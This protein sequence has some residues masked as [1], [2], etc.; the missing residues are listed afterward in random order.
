MTAFVLLAA[1]LAALALGFIVTPLLR[2]RAQAAENDRTDANAAIYR[3]QLAEL[4]AERT[5]GVI[6][7]ERFDE[8]RAEIERRFAEDLT[9]GDAADEASTLQWRGSRLALALGLVVPLVAGAL[10]LLVGTPGAL[11]PAARSRS[12]QQ[13]H[14]VTPEQIDAMVAQLAERLE[15]EP[16]NPEGWHM[17]ARS[18]AALERYAE[19]AKAYAKV[20]EYGGKDAGVLADY[21]DVLAMAAGRNLQGEP[22]RLIEEA[23]ALDPDHIKALALAG[24]AEF[25]RGDFAAAAATWERMLPLVRPDSEDARQ[26]RS[27]VAEARQRAGGAAPPAP[28]ASAPAAAAGSLR[29]TVRL[30]PK[31]GAQ[32]A[33]GDTLFVYARAASGPAMPLAILRRSARELPLEFALDDSM[34]MAPG[35]GLSSQP[36]VVVTARISRSGNALPQPGDLQG[37]SEPVASDAKGVDIL[38]DTVVK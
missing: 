36:R 22:M 37:A 34:A 27:N 2:R 15:R 5:Q 25:D 18:Q 31:L 13:Q 16:N 26:I 24:T 23:L 38:I 11:D 3:A 12:A 7:A 14:E 10:Y 32:T 19:S 33:P 8:T 35:M 1:L 20:I 21:A 17:L 6:S 4:E 28:V 30:S 9:S 29:G